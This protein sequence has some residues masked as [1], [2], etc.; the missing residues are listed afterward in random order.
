MTID[1]ISEAEIPINSQQSQI[2]LTYNLST[3]ILCN[4]YS[5]T[6][7]LFFKRLECIPI[8]SMMSSQK[9]NFPMCYYCNI[10]SSYSQYCPTFNKHTIYS[11]QH[12]ISLPY[13]QYTHI[14]YHNHSWALG[15]FPKGCNV[16]PPET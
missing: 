11:K 6:L 5:W 8:R 4:L 1:F 3:C 12:Q 9:R 16:S 2:N 13:N 7:D 10:Y 14:L 15:L